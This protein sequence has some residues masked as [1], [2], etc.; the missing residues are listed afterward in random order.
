MLGEAALA[1]RRE[2]DLS[3]AQ[4]W[5][6]ESPKL[7]HLL[8]VRVGSDPY[9]LRIDEIAGLFADRHI[10]PVPTPLAELLG[11]AGFRGQVTPVYDLAALLGYPPRGGQRWMILSRHV[12][13]LAFAFDAFDTQLAVMPDQLVPLASEQRGTLPENSAFR[14]HVDHAVCGTS[15]VHPIIRLPSVIA[16][17]Q[18]R[19]DIAG[20][21][22]EHR[23]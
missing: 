19:I 17:V 5:Q 15:A 7:Q 8:A 22:K 12:Q 11:V 18:R 14:S 13:R 2:F 4:A 6:V 3:F 9:A 1:L 16:E 21:K 10:V 23:S 20:Y